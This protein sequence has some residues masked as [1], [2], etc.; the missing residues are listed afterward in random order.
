MAGAGVAGGHLAIAPGGGRDP[1]GTAVAAGRVVAV[2]TDV[3]AVAARVVA[4]P[5][6]AAPAAAMAVVMAAATVAPTTKR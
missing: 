5:V 1:V 2:G 4:D 6:V 3:R